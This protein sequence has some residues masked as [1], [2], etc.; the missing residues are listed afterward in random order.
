MQLETPVCDQ[1]GDSGRVAFIWPEPD[2]AGTGWTAG[3]ARNST[4]T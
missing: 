4:L 3:F 1:K 2:S